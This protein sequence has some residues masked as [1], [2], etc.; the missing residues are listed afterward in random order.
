M[1]FLETKKIGLFRE[2]LDKLAYLRTFV[3]F[4]PYI[5]LAK[6]AKK[7][8]LEQLLFQRFISKKH[9]PICL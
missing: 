4:S 1:V 7:E 9:L 6:E 2:P 3:V 5:C 8:L